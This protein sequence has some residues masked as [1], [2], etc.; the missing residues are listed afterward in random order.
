VKKLHAVLVKAAE[1]V[2]DAV[3]VPWKK[4]A[5]L[6]DTLGG[7]CLVIGAGYYSVGAGFLAAS[8]WLTLRAVGIERRPKS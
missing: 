3:A 6:L 7:V 8:A 5:W 4:R 2:V 1:S